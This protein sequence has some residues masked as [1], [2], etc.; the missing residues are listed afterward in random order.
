MSNKLILSVY[1]GYHDSCITFAN[2][3]EILLHLEAERYFR[4]KHIRVTPEQMEELVDV[5]LKY[6]NQSIDDVDEVLLSKFGGYDF[7]LDEVYLLGRSFTPK[8][9]SHHLSHIG[10]ILPSNLDHTLVICA[11]GWS[12]NGATKF[13]LKK[14]DG[15]EYLADFSDTILTGRF[16]GTITQIIVEPNFDNAHIESP[17]KTMGL[18]ASGSFSQRFHDLIMKNRELLILMYTNGCSRLNE[19]FG[20]SN[21]FKEIWKDKGR[22]DLAFTAQKIWIDEFVQKI[23]EFRHLSENICL[24]GG[25]AL[26]VILN[27]EL[28]R[29]KWFKNVY[30]SPISGDNGQS[31]GAILYH[32][33]EIKCSYPYLGR[34]FGEIVESKDLVDKVVKD[35]L[36]NKIVAW[37]Q[38]RGE[39][40]ARALGHRSFLGLPSSVEMRI[41]L[42]EK[43]K[44]REPYRPISAILTKEFLPQLTD[45]LTLSPYMTFAPQVRDNIKKDLLAIVHNDAT[46]RIQTLSPDDNKVL[47]Q[48]LEEVGRKTGYPV[49]MNS[50]F[51]TAGEP[52]VDTPE[53]ARSTFDNCEAEVLYLNG[54]RYEKS[55][56][57]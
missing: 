4:K 11:D 50:S 45:E 10:T 6:L 49:L 28:V 51:N 1:Y 19:I 15:V 9:T 13:Y 32:H 14:L 57:L 56:S 23:G 47:Y 31:L 40:G 2:R 18:A 42:S 3:Q 17:G 12:E 26:N 36:E 53:E 21:N 41:K 48:I 34:G 38:G 29:R 20:I 52:M 7:S 16:Y 43:V 37:Y 5:G 25:C 54:Q 30:L 44:D 35:L 24:S 55:R 46:S 33:P 8:L 39:V 22:R 27:S